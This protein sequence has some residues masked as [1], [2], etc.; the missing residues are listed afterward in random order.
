[1]FFSAV[2]NN[3]KSQH[4]ISDQCPLCLRDVLMT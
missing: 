1:M 4:D 2:A 3:S